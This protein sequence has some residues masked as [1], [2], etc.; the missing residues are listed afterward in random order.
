MP[1]SERASCRRSTDW[2]R[3][4]IADPERIGVM[5]QSFG[6]YNVYALVTQTDRFKAAAALA[7]SVD[8][9]QAH[10]QF[11][12]TARGYP[13]IENQKSVNWSIYEKGWGLGVPPYDDLNLYW[14]NSP[15]S[16][17]HRVRTPLLLVHGE[18]DK[19]GGTTQ[20]ES[21]FNA[22][23]R[24]GKTARLLRY[25]GESHSLAQSPANIRNIVAETLAWF[26]RFLGEPK[27]ANVGTPQGQSR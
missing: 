11:D 14:R 4:G 26:D 10:G 22:L 17:V 12:P 25:W 3:F 23:Y 19:R 21:F 13:G 24:Q 6:G 9:Q 27:Q 20:A 18:F 1:T 8:L 7:G 15:L 2:L 16:F 5:G